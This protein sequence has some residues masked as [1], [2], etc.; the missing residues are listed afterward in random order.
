MEED[1]GHMLATIATKVLLIKP[2]GCTST[3]ATKVESTMSLIVSVVYRDF[4][5]VM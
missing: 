5:T 3:W 4:V 1:T 2:L